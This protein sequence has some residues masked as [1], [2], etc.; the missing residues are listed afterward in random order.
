MALTGH[1]DGDDNASYLDLA[2]VIAREGAHPRRDRE[3]LFRRIGFS[4]LISNVDDHLRN[5]G[6][7]REGAAGWTLSP[8]YDLNPVP[9]YLKPPILSTA[10]DF[11]DRT[12]D[13]D[14]LL[15]TAT[16]YGLT[17]TRAC[18][19]LRDTA[20]SIEGWDDLARSLGARQAE[21]RDMSGAFEHDRRERALSL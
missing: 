13:I 18:E 12:A 3:E 7:I 6:F 4:I 5:H 16:E 1:R 21:V 11:D 17:R 9:P 15:D 10:I 14:L 19:I 2:D 20:E 8:A